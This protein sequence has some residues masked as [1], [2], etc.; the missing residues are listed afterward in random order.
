MAREG[1]EESG[2]LGILMN[3]AGIN[4]DHTLV[5]MDFPSWRT[6]LAIDL[7]GPFNCTKVLIVILLRQPRPGRGRGVTCAPRELRA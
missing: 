5:K 3:N 2:H 4:S 6:V 1:L 7:D